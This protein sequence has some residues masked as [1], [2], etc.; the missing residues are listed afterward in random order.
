[1]KNMGS[2]IDNWA[3]KSS[4]LGYQWVQGKEIKNI[5]FLIRTKR[6]KTGKILLA[7]SIKDAKFGQHSMCCKLE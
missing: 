5:F 3:D 4:L 6:K 1:M 2:T 7:H